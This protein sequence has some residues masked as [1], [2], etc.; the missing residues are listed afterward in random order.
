[1]TIFDIIPQEKQEEGGYINWHSQ[2]IR[3]KAQTHAYLS[4]WN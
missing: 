4:Y 2:V 3:A 1:M